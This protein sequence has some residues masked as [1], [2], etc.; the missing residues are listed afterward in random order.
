MRYML[1]IDVGGTFT[2]FVAYDSETRAIDVWKQLSV[3]QDPVA[4]ILGGLAQFAHPEA[5]RNARLG[6]TIAT[7]A[8]LER[9][10]ATVAYVTTRGFR[11]VI[12]IQRG[13]RKSHYDMSW[14]KPKP[15]VK[16][17]HCFEVIERVD[18]YGN[19]ITPL[20]EAGAR[21]VARDIRALGE[22]EAVA[23]MLL[24][25]Y[26]NPAHEQRLKAIFAEEAPEL[27]VSISYEVLPKWKEYER[28]S[29][30]IADAYLKPVV[31]QQLRAM[32]RRL[33]EVGLGDHLVMIKSNGG[34]MT[35]DAAADSPVNMMVSGPT[36]GVVA[37]RHVARLLDVR[38]LVT[39]DMGGTSTDVS[40]ITGGRESFT[41]AFEIEW[42]VPIQ[43]PMIDI[44]TIGAGGGSIAWIDKGGMLRV[45]PQSAGASPGP[46]C[47]G[48]GGVEPTVTDANL[49]L[50]RI[51]PE[52]FLGGAMALDV[53]AAARTIETVAG[54]LGHTVE[55]TAMAI[56]RI[57]NNN[58][59]G[60]LR[61]VL[62]ERG[63]DPR[64]FTLLAFG[65]A[66]PLH[67]SEL[68]IEMGIPRAIVPNHPGQFSAYGFILADARVDRQRTT[69]LTSK[70][71]DPA[72]A[73]QVME[74]LVG[75]CI[76]ELEAQGYTRDIR[77]TRAL[78]MRY[79][80]QNYELELPLDFAR[81][82]V[83]TTEEL[84]QAFHDAHKARFGFSIPGEIIEIVNYLATAVSLTPKPELRPIAQAT[85]APV[86]VARRAVGFPDG[87]LELPI[88]RR[89]Q[90]AAGHL[91]DGPAVIEEAASVTVVNPGQRLAVDR[92]GH[93]VIDAAGTEA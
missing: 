68:M 59:V 27:P 92:Y 60:A 81:F 78:E 52:N 50:G 21:A 30:T 90:L 42:G 4:G 70:R 56:V 10:G 75:D 29:T 67:A 48:C 72:R 65:G 84:W 16:R 46:A 26:L 36:G 39:I 55:D 25:S 73:T 28:A 47:Y 79:L 85:G 64:D 88:Y 3:P 45:G 33:T 14:V 87:R 24:F 38:S 19:V 58:M 20:D 57:A 63:L 66:G 23:I 9:K 71:F 7:N 2:D 22:I 13:N 41:T 32:R 40:T 5:I 49:V 51:N 80:G 37:A 34:E 69:Q 62:I 44:R 83:E 35:L 18:K 31:S 82:S 76:A 86:A 91:I 1:G 6:T 93:L 15:L 89:D 17:R 12:F 11:D 61:S 43:I 77:I 54:P 74:E 53:D 8:V